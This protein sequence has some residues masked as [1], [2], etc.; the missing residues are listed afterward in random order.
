MR[1][2]ARASL[3]VGGVQVT[4]EATGVMVERFTLLSSG[5][6]STVAVN[7]GADEVV[8]AGLVADCIASPA[9][10]VALWGGTTRLI[11][12]VPY[13]AARRTPDSLMMPSVM[14]GS[15]VRFAT[16]AGGRAWLA[17]DDQRARARK[18]PSINN[19]Y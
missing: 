5:D 17:A 19:E 15:R 18:T 16:P 4:P 10:G 3:V 11:G 2:T 13:G 12:N 9:G 14:V 1:D 8:L 6:L 7:E